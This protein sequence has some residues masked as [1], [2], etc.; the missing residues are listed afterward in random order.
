MKQPASVRSQPTPGLDLTIEAEPLGVYHRKFFDDQLG[1]AVSTQAFERFDGSRYTPSQLAVARAFWQARTLDEYRSQ[2]GFTELL[3]QLTCLGAS[4]DVVAGAV[5]LVRDEARHVELCRRLVI[6]LGGTSLIPGEPRWVRSDQRQS[7]FM[8]V[9]RT[10]G[11]SLC[12]GETMS[13]ALFGATLAKTSDPLARG[14]LEVITRDESFHGDFGWR[15]FPSVWASASPA[16]RRVLTRQLS[17]DFDFVQQAVFTNCAPT[18]RR[19][20]RNPF[21]ELTLA[22]RSSVSRHC[23]KSKIMSRFERLGLKFR[24]VNQSH[25]QG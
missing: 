5:R 14:V 17:A 15:I 8:R 4:F 20:R 24:L 11:S 13:A 1:P 22:E 12:M 2:V 7:V 16:Q 21:G 3:T 25:L 6:A 10:I 19:P 23:L 18:A 9:A